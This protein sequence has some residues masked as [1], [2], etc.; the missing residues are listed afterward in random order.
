MRLVSLL[1]LATLAACS[2]PAPRQ[3]A[4]GQATPT[5]TP[6]PTPV[7]APRPTAV[8]A[9][10]KSP[11]AAEIVVETYYALLG[12]KDFGRAWSLWPASKERADFIR[13]YADLAEIHAEVGKATNE[14]G[15]CGSIYIDVPVSV[16]ERRVGGV[17]TLRTGKATLRRVNGVDGATPSQLRWHIETIDIN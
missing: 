1:G 3:P 12:Q 2:Q 4:A 13:S 10:E 16:R 8:S 15:A 7:P 9:S 6:T 5:P 11:E 14:E 17:T